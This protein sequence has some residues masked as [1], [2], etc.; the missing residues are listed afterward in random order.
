MLIQRAVLLDGRMVDI[1]L[2]RRIEAIEDRIEPL[3]GE[4]I[5]DARGGT[6]IPGLHDHHVHLRSAAAALTSVRVG[7]G[8]VH[9]LDGLRTALSRAD[10]GE[11][12]WIRAVSYHEAV[13]GPLDRA[14]LDRV[15][16]NVPVRVQHRSGVLWTLNSA[17][18]SAI[19]LQGHPDGRLRSADLRWS[20]ALQRRNTGLSEVS[21]QLS[22]FGVTGVTDATPDLT[23]DDVVE[24]AEARREGKLR[25]RVEVLGPAKRILH[26]DDLDL[27]G[28]TEWIAA[29]HR[30]GGIVAL[31]CVTAVQLIVA[32]SALRQ[33]R[34]RAGDRIEHGAVIPDDCLVDL[35]ELG[36]MVITQ[37]NFVAERGDQY[38]SDVPETE[39]RELWRV[40]SLGGAQI[41]VALSTDLPF[42]D[43]DPWAAMRAAVRR[44]TSSGRVLGKSETIDAAR[45]LGMFLGGP[46][47]PNRPRGLARGGAAD[48]CLLSLPPRDA[49]DALDAA[50]VTATVYD[51]SIV[52]E[53]L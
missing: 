25:Q 21:R 30:Q 40:A 26:D 35:R 53:K 47:R 13:A 51:G 19:G 8:E 45:A 18:L 9:S 10:I 32:I 5:L 46:R 22:A 12:G 16:P 3:R 24:F 17:G 37:P 31:H 29:R 33:A 34:P 44:V 14:A 42:G 2:S 27:D 11:D 49:L 39:H 6:V 36:V 41:P 28:L 4:E 48:L 23:V 1:R 20:H 7:P 38:L 15:S 43:A 52:Y 50:M